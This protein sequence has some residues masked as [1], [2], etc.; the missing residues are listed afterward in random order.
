VYVITSGT[1]K[2]V[3][4]LLNNEVSI[5]TCDFTAIK[6]AARVNPTLF[7]MKGPVIQNKWAGIDI[8]KA[9]NK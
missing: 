5:F 4:T 1:P 2:E 6:T 8:P 9:I 3:H 7:L